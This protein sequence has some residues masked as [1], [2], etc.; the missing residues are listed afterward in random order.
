MVYFFNGSM[1]LLN[2]CLWWFSYEYLR[3]L[4]SLLLCIDYADFS[5]DDNFQKDN[6][7]GWE[8]NF[9]LLKVLMR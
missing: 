6:F 8:G 7:H 5:E 2:V 3:P 4:L 1:S 9:I